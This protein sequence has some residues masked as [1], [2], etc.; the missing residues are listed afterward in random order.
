VPLSVSKHYVHISKTEN[1]REETA[2][3]MAMA[4]TM[5]LDRRPENNREAVHTTASASR[6]YE[7]YP[8]H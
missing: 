8:L 5:T 4:T 2:M 6:H 7:P 1:T 3:A